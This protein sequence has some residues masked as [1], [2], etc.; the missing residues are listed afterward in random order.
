LSAACVL[1]GPLCLKFLQ[2]PF[3]VDHPVTILE[4][5]ALVALVLGGLL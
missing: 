2:E 1:S 3:D 4:V 5:I